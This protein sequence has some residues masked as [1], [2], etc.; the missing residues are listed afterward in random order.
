MS[1]MRRF[2]LVSGSLDA[3]RDKVNTLVGSPLPSDETLTIVNIAH[4]G[5]PLTDALAG[6]DEDQ[7]YIPVLYE[8]EKPKRGRKS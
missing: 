8:V 7:V 1:I 3:A 6:F 5:Q 4:V 2:E